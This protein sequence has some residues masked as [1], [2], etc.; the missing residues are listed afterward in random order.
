MSRITPLLYL[1]GAKEA[2]DLG[3]LR[4]KK[5]RTIINA[6]MEIPNYFPGDFDYIRL[7]LDDTPNQDLSK[8]LDPMAHRIIYNMKENKATYVHCAAGIS[9][10]ASI[11]IYTLM[12]LH[13]WNFD[14]T[15]KFVRTLH[16]RTNPN[17]GF[18][19]QL[20]SKNTSSN[21]TGTVLVN[22]QPQLE[23]DMTQFDIPQQTQPARPPREVFK[24]VRDEN[25]VNP[26]KIPASRY[27]RIDPEEEAETKEPSKKEW[28]QLT[29]DCP[30]CDQPDY[31]PTRHGMYAR[32]FT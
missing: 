5:I 20:V 22:S 3:F 30:D 6:A 13:N 1:G 18:V 7:E 8:V 15:L 23:T 12:K 26:R 19:E 16:A 4:S 31:T 2:Q 24:G 11:V 29:F 9:R 14:K 10:S 32:I 25:V 27:S 17:Y 21:R 28:S